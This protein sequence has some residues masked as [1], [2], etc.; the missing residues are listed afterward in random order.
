MYKYQ[1]RV[2]NYTVSTCQ[3]QCGLHL[4][5]EGL[6]GLDASPYYRLSGPDDPMS[7]QRVV[8]R[9]EDPVWLQGEGALQSKPCCLGTDG[10]HPTQFLDL[11]ARVVVRRIFS[12]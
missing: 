9:K 1:E 5:G 10:D 4:E 7:G 11:V 8:H 3:S 12:P 2:K 6:S